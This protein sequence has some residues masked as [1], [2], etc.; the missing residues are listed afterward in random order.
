MKI[1]I[2]QREKETEC[3]TVQRSVRVVCVYITSNV[4][5]SFVESEYKDE[6]ESY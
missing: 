1:Y 3:A 2:G 4:K 5:F 6:T